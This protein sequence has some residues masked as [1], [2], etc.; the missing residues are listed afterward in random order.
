MSASILDDYDRNHKLYASFTTKV[1]ALIDDLLKSN[2][3]NAHSVTYRV[4]E[5]DSLAR[6]IAKPE[7][8]Y[9]ALAE[10][11][12]ICGIRITT[13]YVD[14]VDRVARVIEQEFSVDAVNSSDKRALLDAD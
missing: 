7:K 2:G 14:D 4:K 8:A 6:K 5:R 13:Y 3:I 10:V 11:T 1:A 12:D 9:T